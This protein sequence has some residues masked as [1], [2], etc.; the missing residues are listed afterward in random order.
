MCSKLHPVAAGGPEGEL[1]QAVSVFTCGVQ[2]PLPPGSG[3]AP[4]TSLQADPSPPFCNA[5]AFDLIFLEECQILITSGLVCGLWPVAHGR[6]QQLQPVLLRRRGAQ[7]GA[8]TWHQAVPS[9]E[10][11]GLHGH[12]VYQCPL[13]AQWNR[14]RSI[15]LS[16]Q[17][18]WFKTKTL[19]RACGAR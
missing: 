4:A 8:C 2:A 15:L 12:A 14:F 10:V 7:R 3:L 17:P 13:R 18:D 11:P 9:P 16:Y 6:A 1:S 19:P 5:L